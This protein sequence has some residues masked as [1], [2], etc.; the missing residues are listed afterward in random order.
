MVQKSS[1]IDRVKRHIGEP[2]DCEGRFVNEDME[3]MFFTA[4]HNFFIY[5][6]IIIKEEVN[7]EKLLIGFNK[8]YMVTDLSGCIIN[9]AHYRIKGNR[10]FLYHPYHAIIYYKYTG[11]FEQEHFKDMIMYTEGLDHIAESSIFYFF[12]AEI[13][14]LDKNDPTLYTRKAIEYA[15]KSKND[16]IKT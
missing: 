3:M 13:E 15:C 8:V 5:S 4:L 11:N 1:I 14:T 6:N 16:T 9:N 2:L 12:L 7:R 10:I